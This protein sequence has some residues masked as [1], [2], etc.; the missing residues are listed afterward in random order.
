MELN[1]R[2][3]VQAYADVG[4]SMISVLTEPKWFKGSLDDLMTAR[5]V[6]E[7]MHQRPAI[8][9]KD[10]IIDVYQLL[11]ARV[12]GAD[13]VLLIVSLL[14]QDHLVELINATHNL[15]M[16][17]LVEVNSVQELDNALAAKA[18]LIG[19]NN[20]DL[21][22]FKVDMDTTARVAD[23]IRERG[24]SLGRDG[25]TLFAL[26]GIRSHA[27]VV[28][29]EMCGARGILIGEFLM[30]SNNI[31]KT[32]EDLLQKDTCRIES[33]DFCLPPP[34]SKVCGI[35]KV[36]YA[37]AALRSGANMIGIVMVSSSPRCVQMEEAKAI[38]KAVRKY[39]ERSGP[40][41]AD[42]LKTHLDIHFP[43]I[44]TLHVPDTA[45]SERTAYLQEIQ[46]GL[47]NYVL[48]DTTVKGQQGGTGVTFDWKIA[49]TF[50]HA[51]VPCLMA[52]GLTPNN[53]QMAISAGLPIG[54]DVSTGVEV[55]KSPGVK[56]L[57]KMAAFLKAVK[58]S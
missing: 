18:R 8:L 23:A 14:S 12:Y 37:L 47:A 26:S 41:L 52:G 46:E 3:Q 39:G 11:E 31:V 2:E 5:D 44:R 49:A 45:L 32:V 35:T 54:V 20:R 16:C 50:A 34:L 17:A 30:K 21:R 1:L 24:L 29:Y 33:G 57:N 42:I 22:S 19:V 7:G 13:C 48:L 36:E 6:V 58:N 43:T 9:R 55:S 38:A 40:I 15:G 25:I 4:A 51:R 53:V 56:D 28:K 27:D 10:F